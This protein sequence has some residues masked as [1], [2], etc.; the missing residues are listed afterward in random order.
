MMS[1]DDVCVCGHTQDEHSCEIGMCEYQDD[2]KG[3]CIC[4]EFSLA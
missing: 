4:P 2:V 1:P 3:F